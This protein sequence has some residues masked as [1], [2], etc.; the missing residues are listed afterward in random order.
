MTCIA[1]KRKCRR[2]TSP[3]SSTPTLWRG[4]TKATAAIPWWSTTGHRRLYG[5]SGVSSRNGTR[6]HSPDEPRSRDRD[7]DGACLQR[8]RSPSRLEPLDWETRLVEETLPPLQDVPAVPLDFPLSKVG[9]YEHPAYGPL[10]VRANGDQ[11]LMQFRNFRFTLVYQGK[12]G[13]LSQE[14]IL[15]G[16]ADFGS[17]LEPEA[18]RVSKALRSVQLRCGR[19]GAGLHPREVGVTS[20]PVSEEVRVKRGS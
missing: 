10:T 3:K 6:A 8:L 4:F 15:D 14:P 13:F 5:A 9:R 1:R 16:A 19:P 12:L 11:L 2:R 17:I 20:P 18:R 7:S